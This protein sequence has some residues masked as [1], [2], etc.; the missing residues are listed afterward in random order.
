MFRT[1]LGA[2]LEASD[3]LE[4]SNHVRLTIHTDYALRVLT[5]IAVAPERAAT[6]AEIAQA[7]RISRHHL[8]K[9]A[10][11][12][13]KAGFV[14]ATRGRGGGLQLKL[15]PEL[16]KI[17]AVVKAAEED[18]ALV[19]CMGPARFCRINGVCRFRAA[20]YKA[21]DAFFASLD[22]MTL[23]DAVKDPAPLI[24]ALEFRPIL[25][26]GK[27]PSASGRNARRGRSARA[28]KAS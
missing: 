15:P 22:E 19:E 12:L 13:T 28:G 21:L 23:A 16:I 18:F 5:Y 9:V 27:T 25:F 1:T 20:F 26:S 11:S 14:E 17:G 4:A 24:G 10:S 6:V 8:V 7:F 2:T 3:R